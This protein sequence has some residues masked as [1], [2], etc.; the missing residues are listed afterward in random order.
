[1]YFVLRQF[2]EVCSDN[3]EVIEKAESKKLEREC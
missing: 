1:M 3:N 2:D